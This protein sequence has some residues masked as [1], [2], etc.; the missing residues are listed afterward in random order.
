MAKK[1]GL[2][3]TDAAVRARQQR[4]LDKASKMMEEDRDPKVRNKYTAEQLG[5]R[6]EFMTDALR[7]ARIQREVDFEAQDRPKREAASELSRETRGV[8]ATPEE[9][10]RSIARNRFYKGFDKPLF[11]GKEGLPVP[12]MKKGG[13]VKAKA[14][15]ASSRAD[16]IAQRGKT[17]GKMR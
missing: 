2:E 7:Q 15:S 17:K 5:K 13:K 10:K 1:Y 6:M 12:G 4:D 14:S 11:G 9:D 3:R 8:K 16:G